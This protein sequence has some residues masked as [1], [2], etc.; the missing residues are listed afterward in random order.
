MRAKGGVR[1]KGVWESFGNEKN[2]REIGRKSVIWFIGRRKLG[3]L[4][5]TK[6]AKWLGESLGEAA[7]ESPPP[8]FKNEVF[9]PNS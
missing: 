8:Q 2:E 3:N 7:G 4:M 6:K 9:K 5:C 1:G